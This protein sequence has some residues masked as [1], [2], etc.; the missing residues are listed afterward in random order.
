MEKKLSPDK[1]LAAKKITNA[2]FTL[3]NFKQVLTARSAIHM[4][5]SKV[6]FLKNLIFQASLL[7]AI[8]KRL[9]TIM[10]SRQTYML[11]LYWKNEEMKFEEIYVIGTFTIP[12]WKVFL[13]EL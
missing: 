4:V 7:R 3:R 11:D 6:F 13:K 12:E 10:A 2:L 1:I 9:Y 5:N 8:R